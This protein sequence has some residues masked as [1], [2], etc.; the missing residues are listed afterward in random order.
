MTEWQPIETAPKDGTTV[1]LYGPCRIVW[2]PRK[3]S[4]REH[5]DAT[6]ATA[7]FRC[8][9]WQAGFLGSIIEPTHWMPLPEPPEATHDR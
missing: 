9:C 4:D 6:I 2:P 5:T 7:Y 3:L 1:I 8:T